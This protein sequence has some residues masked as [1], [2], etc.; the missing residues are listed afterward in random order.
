MA[1]IVKVFRALLL[2]LF[3]YMLPICQTVP[4]ALQT[5]YWLYN[6]REL[7]QCP[8]YSGPK[9]IIYKFDEPQFYFCWFA[10]GFNFAWPMIVPVGLVLAAS[11]SMILGSFAQGKRS[12]EATDAEE[13]LWEAEDGHIH[14]TCGRKSLTIMGYV[15]FDC[16]IMMPIVMFIHGFFP[17]VLSYWNCFVRGNR[18]NFVSAAKGAPSP[19]S[20]LAEESSPGALASFSPRGSMLSLKVNSSCPSTDDPTGCTSCAEVELCA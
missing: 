18:F 14:R 9:R 20:T 16:V 6:G 7:P 11:F 2:P 1:L 5:L 10:G 19:R 4:F 12:D 3:S 8:F 15:L 17:A 13:S